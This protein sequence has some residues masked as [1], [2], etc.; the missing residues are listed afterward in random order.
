MELEQVVNIGS[1]AVVVGL[2]QATKP[3]VSDER[4]WPWIAIGWGLVVNLGG[5]LVLHTE[6]P[7][8]AFYGVLA[9]LAASGLWQA[10]K[11]TRALIT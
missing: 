9:G 1:A 2:V 10:G 11:K 5:A 7:A 3:F 8:A 6:L 4:W